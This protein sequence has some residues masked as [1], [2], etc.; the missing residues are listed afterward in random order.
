VITTSQSNVNV[1]CG[2]QESPLCDVTIVDEAAKSSA[3]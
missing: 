3:A 2:I 1:K